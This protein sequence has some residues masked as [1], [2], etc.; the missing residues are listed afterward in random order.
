MGNKKNKKDI[1]NITKKC[2]TLDTKEKK[3]ILILGLI[4]I[5]L[6]IVMEYIF[7]KS[8]NSMSLARCI[9][10]FGIIAFIGLHFVIGFKKLY[11]IIV[12]NRFK[13]SL[14]MIVVSTIIGFFQNQIE[15][16]EWILNTNT[17]LSL[18]WNIK[19]YGLLLVSYEL[20]N[21]IT[22]QSMSSSIIGTIVVVFSGAV[23]WNFDKIDSLIIGQ[24]I[25]VLINQFFK[26][27]K[28]SYKC[29]LCLGIMASIIAYAFT[30]EGYAISFAYVFIALIIWILI[31]NKEKIKD[32]KTLFIGILTIIVS[33]IGAIIC[34][35]FIPFSYN[36]IIESETKGLSLLY[37]YL[38]NMLLPFN[39]IGENALYGSF[40]SAFPL[41]MLLALYYMFKNDDNAEF[42]LPVTLVAVL[43]TVFCMSGFPTILEKMTLFSNV[44]LSRSIAA[45]N[46]AN[47]YIIFYMLKNI[48]KKLFSI[49]G[50]IRVSIVLMIIVGFIGYP[51]IFAT[52]MFLNLFMVEACLL[53][54]LFLIFHDENYKKT[55]L[56]FLC[57]FTLIGGI[58]VNPI[59]FL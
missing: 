7:I 18:W 39:D 11:T 50:A 12:E 29:M 30:F 36:D 47:V 43:E 16:K 6:A 46:L 48:D 49:S 35:T 55:L 5:I 37:T 45:V 44:L 22:D 32:R 19:F 34:R 14:I 1:D 3:K 38:Y 54:F 58:T 57:I 40:I 10:I 26:E 17:V 23:Q 4:S 28:N 31:K 59:I 15:I 2:E 52:R 41:P 33:V 24:L 56:F 20:F 27:Q 53:S 8:G 21:I 13:L 25:V 9:T 51:E 42:L